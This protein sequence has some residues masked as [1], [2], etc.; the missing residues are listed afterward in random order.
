MKM[1]LTSCWSIG[2]RYRKEMGERPRSP[3]SL[4]RLDLGDELEPARAVHLDDPDG[5][6]HVMRWREL[7]LP[8]RCLDV[9]ALHRGAQLVAVSRKVGEAQVRSPRRV[10]DD[11]D[12]G[13]ALRRELVGILAVL[14]LVRVDEFLVGRKVV[15]DVPR[16]CAAG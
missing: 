6:L 4:A 11:L 9:H 15:A 1:A 14:G 2:P 16:A 3:N 7:E 12:P 13:I 8:Q 10:G 5:L